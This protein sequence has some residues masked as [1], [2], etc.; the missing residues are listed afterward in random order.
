MAI[1]SSRNKERPEL[2]L[3]LFSGAVH[4]WTNHGQ[5]EPVLWE[6]PMAWFLSCGISRHH[7][8][9]TNDAFEVLEN[10]PER[11]RLCFSGTNP[12][13]RA[14]SRTW[15]TIPG[16]HP[17]P[18]IEVRMRMEVEKQWEG[19]NVEFS[20][21]FPYP[22]RLV[23]T[24]LHDAVLFMTRGGSSLVYTLRPDCSVHSPSTGD[25]GPHLFYGLSPPTAAM[26][27]PSSRT[28][29][30]PRSPS[31]TPCAATTSTCTST[32][33]PGRTRCRPARSSR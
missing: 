2:E 21:I 13:R 5:T 7:Y 16:G 14:R 1:W 25:P 12:N 24:W 10:G 19:A 18:R 30:T 4:R 17:R 8:C 11:V 9:N 6:M 29:S 32:S 23:E 31:T 26:S 20:D 15:L 3:D 33:T 27:W 22:S 28:P